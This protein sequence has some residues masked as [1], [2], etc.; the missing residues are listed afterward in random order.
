MSYLQDWTNAKKTFETKTKEKKPSEKVMGI[1]RKSSSLEK[2][3][4]GLD[5]SLGKNNLAEMSKA[6]ESFAG[7]AKSYQ[8]LLSKSSKEDKGTDYQAQVVQLSKALDEIQEGFEKAWA[9]KLLEQV[10][11]FHKLVQNEQT[12]VEKLQEEATKECGTHEELLVKIANA[13]QNNQPKEAQQHANQLTVSCKK[14]EKLFEAAESTCQLRLKNC[15]A[16][17]QVWSPC[18]PAIARSNG[19]YD[20]KSKAITTAVESISHHCAAIKKLLTNALS[21]ALMAKKFLAKDKGA[22]AQLVKAVE[23]FKKKI[24]K[25]WQE[26]QRQGGDIQSTGEGLSEFLQRLPK[27]QR[28]SNEEKE[29]SRLN[30]L[31]QAE[32]LTGEADTLL[33]ETKQAGAELDKEWKTFPRKLCLAPSF[34]GK[35]HVQIILEDLLEFTR[36]ENTVQELKVQVN[37]VIELAKSQSYK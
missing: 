11:V 30:W 8:E 33:R 31:S 16:N 22:E 6:A 34:S 15:K 7:S 32:K 10:E 14:L 3:C 23:E 19:Q 37:K 29:K 4:Q 5:G 21:H 36:V 24:G 12:V 35:Q 25:A 2:A 28:K 17:T 18:K 26:F 20:A 1:F 13:M 9:A 27:D